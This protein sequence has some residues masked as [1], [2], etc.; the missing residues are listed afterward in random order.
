MEEA[1]RLC[2]DN[3]RME[4]DLEVLLSEKPIEINIRSHFHNRRPY[5]DPD[6]QPVKWMKLIQWWLVHRV[7]IDLTITPKI[8]AAACIRFKIPEWK[9]EEAK[10]RFPDLLQKVNQ[11]RLRRTEYVLATG[12][13]PPNGWTP[14]DPKNRST[15]NV[16][17]Y[18]QFWKH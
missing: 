10:K 4:R 14:P 9:W 15:Q 8:E 11:K 12:K 7:P 2:R 13:L 16:P 1:E 17:P 3:R 5:R 6:A 18:A